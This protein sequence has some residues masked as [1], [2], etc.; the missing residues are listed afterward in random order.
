M[1]S[2]LPLPRTRRAARGPADIAVVHGRAAAFAALRRVLA[3]P[4][5]G[6]WFE[7]RALPDGRRYLRWAGLFEFIVAADGRR[8]VSRRLAPASET[9]RAFETY[10][11]GQVL[12]FV[13]IARGLEP[14]HATAVVVG[15]GAVGFLGDCG[16]GKSTLGAAFVRAGHPLLTDDLLVLRDDAGGFS[17]AAGPPR[18]KLFRT[19]ARRVLGRGLR[20]TPMN[21]RGGKLVFPLGA[22]ATRDAAPLRALYVLCPRRTGGDVVI[23]PLS[24]RR[25]FVELTRNTFNACVLDAA[26]LARQ[27]DLA[28]RVAAAVP[29]KTLT[30]PRGLDRLAAVRTAVEADVSV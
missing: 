1:R 3:P 21:G 24:P 6:T 2:A 11:L 9:P 27:F 19:P 30:Y 20:G 29:V 25:A 4:L 12:S 16:R 13:L 10:L 23:R 26:R 28:A 17:A 14:L 22:R 7:E 18:L 5:A 15:D 8:I